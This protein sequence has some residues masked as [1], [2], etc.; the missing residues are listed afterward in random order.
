MPH[1]AAISKKA[2]DLRPALAVWARHY[3]T[4]EKSQSMLV[5]MTIHR[6]SSLHD[7]TEAIAEQRLHHIARMAIFGDLTSPWHEEVA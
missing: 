1:P 3:C 2:E 7:T 5:D 4:D 6:L